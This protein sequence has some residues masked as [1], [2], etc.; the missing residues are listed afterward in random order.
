MCVWTHSSPREE[1]FHHKLEHIEDPRFYQPVEPNFYGEEEMLNIFL[2]ENAGLIF[3]P[4]R[5]TPVGADFNFPPSLLLN[6][7]RWVYN[8]L[9]TLDLVANINNDESLSWIS[10]WALSW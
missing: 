1:L 6:Q 2:C 8:I 5:F 4:H 3:T 9:Q 10:P 7:G